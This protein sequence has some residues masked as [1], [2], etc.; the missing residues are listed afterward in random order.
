M[1]NPLATRASARAQ[2]LIVLALSLGQSAVYSLVQLADKMSQGP[3][4][5]QTTS[6]NQPRNNRE[7]FDALYRLLDIGFALVPVALV[8]YFVCIN[9]R[10]T[11]RGALNRFG[12][13]TN[14]P[15]FDLGTGIGLYLILGIGTL[16]VYAAGRALNL[17][18]ALVPSSAAEYWWTV[19]ILILAALK[20][21]ILEQFV[22]IGFF[23]DRTRALGWS[24]AATIITSA[25]IRG[26]YHSYQGIG[27]MI[28]NIAMGLIFGWFYQRTGR[29]TPMII[30]HA[31]LDVSAFVGFALVSGFLGFG[32]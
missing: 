27:P 1:Q 6:M 10:T 24:P 23:F 11:L 28:G 20:N 31:L 13:N 3:L 8:I 2:L 14:R 21:G 32:S 15:L 18:T 22:M 19:P 30:A 9:N 12:V 17:T 26:A 25:L 7:L 4:S 29:L 5:E 16:G